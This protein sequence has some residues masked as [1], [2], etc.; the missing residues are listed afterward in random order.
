MPKKV[1]EEGGLRP[2]CERQG[3]LVTQLSFHLWSKKFK[4]TTRK[5]TQLP[6]L[7]LGRR[8]GHRKDPGTDLEFLCT[9][10]LPDEGDTT[11]C[12]EHRTSFSCTC[13]WSGSLPHRKHQ[14]ICS[15]VIERAVF[16]LGVCT[17]GF[18]TWG[19]L[20]VHRR[21]CMSDAGAWLAIHLSFE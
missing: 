5:Q 7:L 18:H 19:E 1:D 6:P 3:S 4:T 11:M 20:Q 10:G 8:K 15:G 14:L 9:E 21:N 13:S 2:G 12:E 17:C 16:A